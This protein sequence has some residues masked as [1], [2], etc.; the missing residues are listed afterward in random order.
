M[1]CLQTKWNTGVV[2]EQLE[3]ITFDVKKNTEHIR[4]KNAT[5]Q[6]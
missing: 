3:V 6:L 4:Q 2:S 5:Q 1:I